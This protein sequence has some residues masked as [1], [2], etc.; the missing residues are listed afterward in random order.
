MLKNLLLQFTET[1]LPNLQIL[2]DVFSSSRANMLAPPSSLCVV[3]T[4]LAS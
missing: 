2:S 4:A 1:K 3:A